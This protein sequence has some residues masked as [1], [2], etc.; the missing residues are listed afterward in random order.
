MSTNLQQWTAVQTNFFS[1]GKFFYTNSSAAA[2]PKRFY[3]AE[4]P[5]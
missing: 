3:R 2:Y 1:S 5:P 4:T